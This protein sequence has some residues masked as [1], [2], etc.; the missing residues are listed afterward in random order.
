[1]N[2]I[3][4]KQMIKVIDRLGRILAV[5]Y[6][7]TLGDADLSVKVEHLNRCGFSNIE[8][9]ELLGTTA[10]NINNALHRARHSKP[11]KTRKQNIKK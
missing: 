11:K 8:I 3:D 1:M 6:A 4:N 10:N 7:H 5:L 2:D 9:A